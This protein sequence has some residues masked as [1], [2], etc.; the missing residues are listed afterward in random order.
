MFAGSSEWR[1]NSWTTVSVMLLAS[2]AFTLVSHNRRSVATT[3]STYRSSSGMASISVTSHSLV[4]T[5]LMQRD[6]QLPQADRASVFVVDADKIP[7]YLFR[8]PRIIWFIF[9]YSVRA[10]RR[11]QK[12]GGRWSP[13]PWDGGVVDTL[14]TRY[15]ASRTAL[16]AL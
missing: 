1:V 14:E 2:T 3:R 11:S 16:F 12:F 4:S 7:S 13:A 10:C 6:G 8:S 15:N 5:Q 9:S